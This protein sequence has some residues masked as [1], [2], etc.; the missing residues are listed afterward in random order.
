MATAR[1][2]ELL[3]ERLKN[4]SSDYKGENP[5]SWG[6]NEYLK[7]LLE[8]GNLNHDAAIGSAKRASEEGVNSLSEAQLKAIALD[9]LKSDTYMEECPNDWC[10]EKIAWGDMST[11]LWE[12]QCYHCVNRQEK[13]DRE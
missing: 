2:I 11:A 8:E 3:T 1:E 13:M 4:D 5:H 10:G 7:Q 9:M 12:G 6:L